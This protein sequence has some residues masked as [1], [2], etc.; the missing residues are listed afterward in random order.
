MSGITTQVGE[1]N[2][3]YLTIAGG[4]MVQKSTEDNPEA[5][6]REYEKKDFKYMSYVPFTDQLLEFDLLLF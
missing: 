3:L 5:R 6:K 1:S 2:V 4:N